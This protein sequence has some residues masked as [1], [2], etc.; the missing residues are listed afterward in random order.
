MEHISDGPTPSV[1]N[2]KEA[3]AEVDEVRDFDSIPSSLCLI[4][5]SRVSDII[6]FALG[7]VRN[8]ALST[9]ISLFML[10]YVLRNNSE[11]RKREEVIFHFL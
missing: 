11:T 9:L 3:E 7:T 6:V 1:L 5:K 4:R 10:L 8:P 2:E